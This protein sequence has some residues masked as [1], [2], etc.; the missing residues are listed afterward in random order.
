MDLPILICTEKIVIKPK[1]KQFF[2]KLLKV[3]TVVTRPSV[4]VRHQTKIQCFP[5]FLSPKARHPS[6]SWWNLPVSSNLSSSAGKVYQSRPAW[7]FFGRPELSPFSGR[8]SRHI[9]YSFFM[10]FWDLDRR[11]PLRIRSGFAQP[12]PVGNLRGRGSRFAARYSVSCRSC[13]H[14]RDRP[15]SGN[16]ARS[17]HAPGK[18]RYLLKKF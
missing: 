14:T 17:D 18:I 16:H 12:A 13:V 7:A 2:L 9:I 6:S 1:K 11:G 8:G 10:D 5:N 3:M 15:R 4:D